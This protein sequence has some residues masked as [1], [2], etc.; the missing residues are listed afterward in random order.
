MTRPSNRRTPGFTLVELLVVIAIIGI[1]VALLL[2]AVQSAREAAR[3]TQCTSQLKN[4]SL[5]MINLESSSGRLPSAGW[6]GAYTGDPDRGTGAD[7]PGNWQ[8][9]ILQFVEESAIFD[10]G[11]GLKN[12]ARLDALRTRDGTPIKLY[13]CPSRRDGGPYQ[14]L[15]SSNNPTSLPNFSGDGNGVIAKQ[16][17]VSRAARGD[18]AVCVGDEVDY[19]PRCIT[20]APQNYDKSVVGFPPKINAF[21]GVSFCGVAVKLKQ[22]T[23]GTSKTIAVGEKWLPVAAYD[24]TTFNVGDDWS[25]YNGYQND[26]IRSTYYKG[27]KSDGTANPGTH[28]PRS[29]SDSTADP[30]DQDE[31]FG[32]AHPAGCLFGMCDG[33]VSLV[34]YDVDP[35]VF[36]QMGHRA[37]GGEVKITTR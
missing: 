24:G 34:Q 28:T 14:P 35:E 8:Y 5:G 18:Y 3:R 15:D 30:A 6:P 16:Y 9:G 2:P 22:I 36:R 27:R 7:Q 19:D 1:L 33:S 23:D 37:D 13:N 25:M 11:R 21:S 20:I 29:D 31:L 4:I 26:S 12:Q 17:S 10:I 32:S